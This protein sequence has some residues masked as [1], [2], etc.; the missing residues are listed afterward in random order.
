MASRCFVVSFFFSSGRRHT[1]LQGDWSSDV[2]SSDLAGNGGMGGPRLVDGQE[3]QD[4]ESGK[5]A[6]NSPHGAGGTGGDGRGQIVNHMWQGSPGTAGLG[7][8]PGSGGG[9]GGAGSGGQWF[10]P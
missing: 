2:C 9:G 6:G 10:G 4:G 5:N 3:T 1:R 8:Q 7:A